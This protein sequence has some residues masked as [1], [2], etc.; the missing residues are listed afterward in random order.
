V[1]R[2]GQG[3][4]A[5]FSAITR[6]NPEH[7][8]NTAGRSRDETVELPPAPA[9]VAAKISRCADDLLAQM[10]SQLPK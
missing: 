9:D 4:F 8:G 3:L 7:A 1:C 2:A 10:K 5:G 6:S